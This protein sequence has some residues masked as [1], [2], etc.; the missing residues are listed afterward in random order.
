[1]TLPSFCITCDAH[2]AGCTCG[3]PDCVPGCGHTGS[4]YLEPLAHTHVSDEQGKHVGWNVPQEERLRWEN[5]PA[6]VKPSKRPAGRE[7]KPAQRLIV[8]LEGW[9]FVDR[10]LEQN[11]R[12][13]HD[14]E[15]LR[16]TML[17]EHVV[18]LAEAGKLD[19][20]AG[21]LAVKLKELGNG[22]SKEEQ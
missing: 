1:M 9:M 17:V 6:N 8:D 16:V 22:L 14:R 7:A 20:P 15:P 10:Q 4:R 11:V 18:Q 5:P 21:L 13:A 3:Q 19:N 12:D 2:P